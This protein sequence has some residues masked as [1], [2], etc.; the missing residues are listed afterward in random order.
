MNPKEEAQ[1]KQQEPEQEKPLVEK[2][3]SESAD[4]NEE[5]DNSDELEQKK[6]EAKEFNA[7]GNIAQN[8]I[9]IQDMG[10]G[11]FTVN[12]YAQKSAPIMPDLPVKKKFDLRKQ[13][14]CIHFIETFKNSEYFSTAVILCVFEAVQLADLPALKSELVRCLPV[15]ERSDTD[16]AGALK[17]DPYIAVNSILTVIGGEIFQTETGKQC[18]S[19]GENHVQALIHVLEQFPALQESVSKFILQITDTD[20]YHTVFYDHQVAMFLVEMTVL[21]I[22]DVQNTILPLLYE[23]PTNVNLLAVFIYRLLFDR[24]RQE[25]A[26]AIIY[27]WMQSDIEWLWKAV[28]YCFA[29]FQE[30]GKPFMQELQLKKMLE[31]KIFSFRGGDLNFVAELSM[32]AK[33]FRDLICDVL[34]DKYRRLDSN[35][36][37]KRLA[38]LYVNL[39]RKGYYR[40][41]ASFMTLP[42]VACDTKKQQDCLT[43]ILE[44]VMTEYRFRKQ[45]YAILRAYLKE[46]SQYEY[47]DKL[48]SHIAAYMFNLS[49]GGPEYK[50]DLIDFLNGCHGKASKQIFDL[51]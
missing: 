25:V 3:D 48:I 4:K 50:E 28:C 5:I 14:D 32:Q 51:L 16:E 44:K 46:L 1:N 10:A 43:P 42:F 2:N 24:N 7:D 35:N 49:L 29:L 40:V 6:R 22:M 33:C 37:R 8:Q 36:N 13:E 21:N 34:G 31:N 11:G 30:N 38:Q 41:S 17:K 12:Y 45:I 19:M 20:Q 15:E 9:F 18:I 39:I 27:Q 26:D 47:S 23:N